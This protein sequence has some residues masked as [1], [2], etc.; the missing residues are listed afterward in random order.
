MAIQHNVK[1]GDI[2]SPSLNPVYRYVVDTVL[3]SGCLGVG[4]NGQHITTWDHSNTMYV[5]QHWTHI[6]QF[7]A[8]VRLPDGF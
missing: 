3:P 8:H 2:L 5:L 1:V 7:P 4:M 6:P